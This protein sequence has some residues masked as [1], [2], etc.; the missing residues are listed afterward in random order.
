[1][2]AL[3]KPYNF[4]YIEGTLRKQKLN[5]LLSSTVIVAKKVAFASSQPA[6][7]VPSYRCVARVQADEVGTLESRSGGS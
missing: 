4:S 7:T 6:C 3:R 2:Q 1:M 5:L